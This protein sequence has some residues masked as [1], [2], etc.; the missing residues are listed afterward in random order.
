M[1]VS[2]VSCCCIS[3]LPDTEIIPAQHVGI[4]ARRQEPIT[5]SLQVRGRTRKLSRAGWGGGC[6]GVAGT[7]FRQLPPPSY[8]LLISTQFNYSQKEKKVLRYP[9][10]C[11][12]AGAAFRRVRAFPSL[13]YL[14]ANRPARRRTRKER[15]EVGVFQR[16]EPP[17]DNCHSRHACTHMRAHPPSAQTQ[18]TAQH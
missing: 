5:I 14:S 4:P 8:I 18:T 2:F 10:T 15:R 1:L 7:V 6:T 11:S 3:P 16:H 12:A 9:W 17:A 13:C